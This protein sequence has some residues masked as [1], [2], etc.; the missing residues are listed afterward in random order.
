MDNKNNKQ[1]YWEVKNFMGRA[2]TPALP[3]VDPKSLKSS[4]KSVLEQNKPYPFAVNNFVQN[5][6]I[7][8]TVSQSIYTERQNYNSQLPKEIKSNKNILNNNPFYLMEQSGESATSATKN[9]RPGISSDKSIKP[10]EF[11]KITTP[12][13]TPPLRIPDQKLLPSPGG[14]TIPKIPTGAPGWLKLLLVGLG[15]GGLVGLGKDLFGSDEESTKDTVDLETPIPKEEEKPETVNDM[16]NALRKAHSMP[17][18]IYNPGRRDLSAGV[19][20]PSNYSEWKKAT[21][22]RNAAIRDSNL[23]LRAISDQQ[24]EDMRGVMNQLQDLR[25]TNPNDPRIGEL[26]KQKNEMMRSQ[27]KLY[28]EMHPREGALQRG[29]DIIQGNRR[30]SWARKLGEFKQ[31][32]GG[33]DFDPTNPQHQNIM[34][35]QQFPSAYGGAA[36][37][38]IDSNKALMGFQTKEEESDPITGEPNWDGRY[39]T[40]GQR[41]SLRAQNQKSQNQQP[42]AQKQNIGQVGFTDDTPDWVRRHAQKFGM[43]SAREIEAM[44]LGVT[45]VLKGDATAPMDTSLSASEVARRGQILARDRQEYKNQ[46]QL[47]TSG[48]E[49]GIGVGRTASQPESTW[50]EVARRSVKGDS[51]LSSAPLVRR[52]GKV[53]AQT[54]NGEVELSTGSMMTSHYADNAPTREQMNRGR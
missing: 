10:Y 13:K 9:S 40:K 51:E 34:R 53:Y 6:N 24:K 7:V 12:P 11:S 43:D 23:K 17:V 5:S 52:S 38:V 44:R 18:P 47:T 30:E 49:T 42:V 50:D 19:S 28:D 4:V 16:I 35:A 8:N 36:K 15:V 1:F 41:E 37:T 48:R 46:N 29:L 32:T 26:E 21:E 2:K 54:A 25:K 20:K 14:S 3:P 39:L 33:I 45:S 22:A 31:T 27:R